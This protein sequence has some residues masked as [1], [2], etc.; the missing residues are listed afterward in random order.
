MADYQDS[1]SSDNCQQPAQK[2]IFQSN[3]KFCDIS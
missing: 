1:S 2:T 3:F